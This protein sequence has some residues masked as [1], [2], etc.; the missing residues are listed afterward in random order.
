MYYDVGSYKISKEKENLSTYLE[1]KSRPS[2]ENS[3]YDI[4]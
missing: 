2:L 3:Y 4:A 1:N